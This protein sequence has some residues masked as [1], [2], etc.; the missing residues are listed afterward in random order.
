[1]RVLDLG[2]GT[3]CL[4]LAFLH[5]RPRAFGMGVDRSEAA[6]RL[7]R[8]NARDLGLS[9]RSAFLCGD[10]A[11]AIDARYDLVLSNPPYIAAADVSGLMPDVAA[12]EP[13]A[14]LDGGADGLVAYRAILAALPIL[15]DPIRHR[16]AGTGRRP[17]GGGRGIGGKGRFFRRI[18]G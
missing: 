7:A 15:S 2:I 14:A 16:G 1:M 9:G 6:A 10:W 5:E 8:D 17:G 11:A 13:R 18:P 12:Y 3:G 4:L